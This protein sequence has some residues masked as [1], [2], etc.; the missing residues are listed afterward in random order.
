MR[1]IVAVLALVALGGLPA[2]AQPAGAK[3]ASGKVTAISASSLTIESGS[4]TAK[5]S[6]TFVLDDKTEVIARGATRATKGQERGKATNLIASGDSV[7]VSYDESGS[8]M[9][10]AQVRVTAKAKKS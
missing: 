8:A 1:S 4:G 10:A 3:Q 9:H 5:K 2:A 6:Q 7:T